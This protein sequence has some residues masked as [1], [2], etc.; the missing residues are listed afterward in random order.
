MCRLDYISTLTLQLDRD[1]E[2]S[3][4]RDWEGLS[5]AMYEGFPG[6]PE[7][8]KLGDTLLVAAT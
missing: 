8:L 4:S 5:V 3:T 6:Y 2:E 7:P 1:D